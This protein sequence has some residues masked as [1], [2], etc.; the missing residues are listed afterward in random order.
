[1][2][3]RVIF[4]IL[5]VFSLAACSEKKDEKAKPLP[6]ATSV[7]SGYTGPFIG[8]GDAG[9]EESGC[10]EAGG[11][12]GVV[13]QVEL[14]EE[15][16]PLQTQKVAGFSLGIPEGYSPIIFDEEVV[17][18]ATSAETIGGFTVVL[19][20]V[21]QDDL[22]AILERFDQPDFETGTL[23]N[24]PVLKG[25]QLPNKQVGTIALFEAEN[26]R[27]VFVEG[28]ASPGYWP[29]FTV[30]FDAILETVALNS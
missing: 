15:A 6:T 8:G 16:L 9:Q 25:H 22:Q 11:C 21:T 30:T 24:N 14:V 26:G 12:G 29:A 2:N 10:T 17:I 5:V 19:R 20:E 7:T 3:K 27:M 23:I 1:M 18:S 13:E 28:F 4:L